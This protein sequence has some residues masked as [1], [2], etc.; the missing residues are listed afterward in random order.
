MPGPRVRNVVAALWL[1]PFCCVV[2]TYAHVATGFFI[3]IQMIIIVIHDCGFDGFVRASADG[4]TGIAFLGRLGGIKG[5]SF[6]IGVPSQRHLCLGFVHLGL[7]HPSL[8]H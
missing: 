6:K 2:A 4:L 5:G 7:V 1:T 8:L 3:V